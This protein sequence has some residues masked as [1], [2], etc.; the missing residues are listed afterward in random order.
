[1]PSVHNDIEAGEE[2]TTDHDQAANELLSFVADALRAEPTMLSL[3]SGVGDVPGWDSFAQVNLLMKIE[4]RYQIAF[5]ADD[6]LS[7]ETLG[8]ILDVVLRLST[9]AGAKD[10]VSTR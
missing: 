1:V 8:D 2:M 5:E 9:H 6:L 4:E 7:M 3:E 10:I